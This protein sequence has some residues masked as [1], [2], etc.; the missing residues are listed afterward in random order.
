M[1]IHIC[2][3]RELETNQNINSAG[4]QN[5]YMLDGSHFYY[6]DSMIAAFAAFYHMHVDLWQTRVGRVPCI[7]QLSALIKQYN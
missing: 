7:N 4:I 1:K 3:Q 6:K 2:I 5:T